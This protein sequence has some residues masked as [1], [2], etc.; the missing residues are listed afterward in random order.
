MKKP[1]RKKTKEVR[2]G[3]QIIGGRH[4]ILVQ[5]MT[6]TKTSDVKSTVE[7]ILALVEAGCEIVRV[8]VPDKASVAAL[9]E[10]KKRIPVPLVADIHF[11]ASLAMAALDAGCDKI[12]INPGN[13]GGPDKFKEVLGH[14]RDKGAAVRI[15]VNSGSVEPDLLEKYS[16]PTAEAMVQSAMRYLEVSE[17]VGFDQIVFSIKASNTLDAL[18]SNRRFSALSD[19]PLHIGI[20]EAGTRRYGAIKSAVGLGALLLDGIGDT[21]RVSLTGDPLQEIP[22]AYDILKASGARIVSPEVIACPTCGRLQYNM[23]KVA[24]EIERRLAGIKKPL[25][26]AVMGCVVNGP[27]EAREAD[28]ALAGGKGEAILFKRGIEIKRVK[29]SEMVE[30]VVRAAMED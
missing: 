22:V 30:E 28:I 9:S 21:I 11:N 12:R 17:S 24:E 20:T 15:G 8:A 27:G 26:V 18:E 29:E 4:P 14:A 19:Y 2:V 3:T 13:I 16:G 6:S 23:E 7:Q 1:Q 10:N 25:R 5:S